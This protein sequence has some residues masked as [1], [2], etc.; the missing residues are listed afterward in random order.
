MQPWGATAAP[1]S[2]MRVL[3]TVA[4]ARYHLPL[5]GLPR[6]PPLLGGTE[7]PPRC[8]Q[9]GGREGEGE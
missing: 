6:P 4:G 2:G 7:G 3:R 5:L 8:P 1:L 9:G